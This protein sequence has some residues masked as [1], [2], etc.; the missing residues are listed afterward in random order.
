M[1]T[2]ALFTTTFGACPHLDL[3][4]DFLAYVERCVDDG[5]AVCS[6]ACSAVIIFYM[7][8]S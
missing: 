6:Y 7:P 8:L 3:V 4:T 1:Q 5:L 2:I